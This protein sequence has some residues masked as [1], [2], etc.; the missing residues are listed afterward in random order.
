MKEKKGKKRYFFF[1]AEVVSSSRSSESSS[2]SMFS[3]HFALRWDFS[4]PQMNTL[5]H[6]HQLHG[7]QSNRP[8]E[9]TTKRAL[10]KNSPGP[11]H[12]RTPALRIHRCT[13][14]TIQKWS[15]CSWSSMPSRGLRIWRESVHVPFLLHRRYARSAD[16]SAKQGALHF[17][18]KYFRAPWCKVNTSH[19]LTGFFRRELQ[20]CILVLEI[21]TGYQCSSLNNFYQEHI[22]TQPS[23][24]L[25]F[26]SVCF[27]DQDYRRDERWFPPLSQYLNSRGFVSNATQNMQKGLYTV[28]MVHMYEWHPHTMH[29]FSQT[30][31]TTQVSSH[32][33]PWPPWLIDTYKPQTGPDTNHWM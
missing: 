23:R 26:F 31:T 14:V 4:S 21:S 13:N 16:C 25:L 29:T 32:I 7:K 15:N 11:N 6:H 2:G 33:F 10:N 18:V 20:T 3:S 28:P 22:I 8:S 12:V 30:K 9:I 5:L 17:F 24:S 19:S 1:A 27:C